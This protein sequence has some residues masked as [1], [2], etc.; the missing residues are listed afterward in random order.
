MASSMKYLGA[1]TDPGEW[2]CDISSTATDL[3]PGVS[4]S[5]RCGEDGGNGPRLICCYGL[6]EDVDLSA[7]RR[8]AEKIVA[9]YQMPDQWYPNGRKLQGPLLM[10]KIEKWP[11]LDM[12]LS[13]IEESYSIRSSKSVNQRFGKMV[14][15]LE[16]IVR[17]CTGS[18][19]MCMRVIELVGIEAIQEMYDEVV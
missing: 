3:G 10:P 12:V 7:V 8:E 6:R 14:W 9:K 1:A 16:N 18:G 13:T 19:E 17:N 15:S 5:V 11:T 4:F 2:W